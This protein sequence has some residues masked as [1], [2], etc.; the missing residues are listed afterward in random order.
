MR[1]LR[2]AQLAGGRGRGLF[3]PRPDHSMIF[4]PHA[5]QRQVPGLFSA[6]RVCLRVD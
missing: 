5:A 2:R 3:Q 6:V 4:L 1:R